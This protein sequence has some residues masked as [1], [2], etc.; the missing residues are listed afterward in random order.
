[1]S[2]TEQIDGH[3]GQGS[4]NH[5]SKRIGTAEVGRDVQ[6]VEFKIKPGRRDMSGWGG[7]Q[8]G[9]GSEAEDAPRPVAG[10]ELHARP[11]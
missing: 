2:S 11:A 8:A 5:W 7:A 6:T 10:G 1:M 9:G 4:T 3:T